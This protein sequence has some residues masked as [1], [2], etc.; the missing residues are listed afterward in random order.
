MA[1]HEG[2]DAF[3]ENRYQ[4]LLEL[5]LSPAEAAAQAQKE[6]S[7]GD[8]PGPMA[9]G[10]IAGLR[11]GG[12]PGYAEDGFVTADVEEVVSEVSPERKNQIEGNQMAEDAMN[13]IM[14]KFM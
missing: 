4:E 3:L 11:H 1:S 12:R 5:N 14:Y 9:T 8:V 6:L 7:S 13:K 10:G 2:N